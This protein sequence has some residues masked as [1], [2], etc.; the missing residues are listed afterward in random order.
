VAKDRLA[1]FVGVPTSVPPAIA[2]SEVLAKD[3]QVPSGRPAATVRVIR[4][5]PD[6]VISRAITAELGTDQGLA[7]PDPSKDILLIAVV[8]RYRPARPAVGFVSGFGLY[9]G[10]MASSVSHDS[11]NLIGVGTDPALLAQALNAVAAQ[12]GGYNATDG[13]SS[14]RLELPVAGLMTSLPWGEVAKKESEVNAFL[15][16]MG[17][18]LPAPFMTLSFQSLLTV[19]ELKISDLGLV[20]TVRGVMVSPVIGEERPELIV[21]ASP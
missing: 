4:V 12:G 6:Q 11:H 7:V 9:K 14:V 2:A 5:L 20:D 17:C 21:D 3:L 13:V 16:A 15:Q 1:L 10:A 18:P 8:N 19:P